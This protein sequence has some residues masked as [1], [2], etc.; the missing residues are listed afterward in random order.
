VEEFGIVAVEAMAAGRPVVAA[1]AGGALE[2]V[3]DG[4]SGVLVPPR[5]VDALAQALRDTDFGAFDGAAI[6]A[7]AQTFSTHAFQRKLRQAVADAAG[8]G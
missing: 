7:H 1:G 8:G 5:D 2:T 3:V 4:L 6:Q